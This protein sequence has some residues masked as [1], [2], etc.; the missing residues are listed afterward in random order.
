MNPKEGE[1]GKPGEQP[2]GQAGGRGGEGGKGG[3]GEPE[4]VGGAGG[5]GGRGAP[6]KEGPQ[7]KPGK[8]GAYEAVHRYR[9]K[10][11]SVWIIVFTLATGY[12]LREAREQSSAQKNNVMQN[13]QRI[14]DI[15]KSRTDSCRASYESIREVF[16]QFF[17]KNP[18][19][20]QRRDRIKFD[21][22]IDELKKRCVRQTD[23]NNEN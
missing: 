11:L 10:A 19:R 17:P 6:G 21:N 16:T 13:Q 2:V 20:Q 23:P 1:P 5:A 7:G 9:W 22:K 15:Q 8:P 4:G 3:E 14:A 12:A 18:T